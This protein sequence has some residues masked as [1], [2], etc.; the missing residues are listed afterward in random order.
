MNYFCMFLIYTELEDMRIMGKVRENST[1]FHL[2]LYQ[3]L[4]TIS[5]NHVNSAKAAHTISGITMSH[6]TIC[7]YLCLHSKLLHPGGFFL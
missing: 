4:F 3:E 2:E 5:E 6:H 7:L 1:L